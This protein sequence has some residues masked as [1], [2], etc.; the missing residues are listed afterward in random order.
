MPK[1]SNKT[2]ENR[3]IYTKV[4]IIWL[5]CFVIFLIFLWS[6]PDM[7]RSITW[8]QPENAYLLG[9]KF[10]NQG[11]LNNAYKKFV[12]AESVDVFPNEAHAHFVFGT[13]SEKLKH[14]DQAIL[15]YEKSLELDGKNLPADQALANLYADAHQE[16]KAVLM[17][18]KVNLQM[19]QQ[20]MENKDFQKA[21]DTFS[22]INHNSI[23]YPLSETE[24]ALCL[25]K[26]G[27]TDLAIK[28]LQNITATDTTQLEAFQTLAELYQKKGLNS[29]AQEI[30]KQ[31]K[32]LTPGIE[33]GQNL[34]NRVLFLGYDISTSQV[35]AGQ[36]FDITY[37]WKCL[38][39]FYENYI[40][41]VQ[42]YNSK[43]EI[44]FTNWHYPVNGTYPTTKWKPG[45]VIKE[46]YTVS[47]PA[48]TLPDIYSIKI[49]VCTIDKNATVVYKTIGNQ[50][51]T[52][53]E[54]KV[55]AP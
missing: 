3:V 29:Q 15:E 16:T 9:E 36:S 27:K 43:D 38:T 25:A 30:K 34:A 14:T 42:F 18:D 4:F 53:G 50:K 31:I 8:T 52:I 46:K 35:K 21:A 17:R 40:I 26:L 37:Y 51:Y 2:S 13:V 19:G 10:L 47:V 24:Y 11:D 39:S 12:E 45:E 22:K 32:E 55:T 33:V 28:E 6:G 5:V 20:L 41:G 44:P 54:I 7:M 49:S 23:Y 48:N 1:P